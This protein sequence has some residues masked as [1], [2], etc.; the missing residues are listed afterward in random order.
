MAP[1]TVYTDSPITAAKAS[2]PTPQTADAAQQASNQDRYAPPPT[3]TSASE[4]S[5]TGYPAPQPAARPSQPV[6]T[7]TPQ[8]QPTPTQQLSE[9]GPPAPQPGPVP[10][11]TPTS[12]LP[13]PPKA[14]EAMSHPQTSNPVTAMPPQMSYQ[15]PTSSYAAGRST[16]MGL[17]H[18]SGPTSLPVGGNDD[19]SHP[20]GYQQDSFASEFN[21]AQRA[22][23]HD[24]GRTDMNTF[25]SGEDESVWDTAKKWA[26][27]AG[28]SLAAAEGE[29]WKR[30]NK[31]Q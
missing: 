30:I 18:S 6:P 13:P 4:A 23:H 24:Y 14:G 25:G 19:L 21:S 29:V 27:A 26:S 31:E 9:D 15:P 8:L 2:G 11:A 10:V 7:G 16:T 17:P 22:A 12:H 20:P 28:N 5:P 1:I 3:T